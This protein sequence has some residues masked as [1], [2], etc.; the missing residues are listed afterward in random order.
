MP[1][2]ASN[3][4]HYQGFYVSGVVA[5]G[6]YAVTISPEKALADKIILTYAFP[7]DT[8]DDYVSGVF[9]NPLGTTSNAQV[10][11]NY[12]IHAKA[13]WQDDT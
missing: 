1:A 3:D 13:I 10:E 12:H 5:G 8:V 9:Y 2:I 7:S 6:D 11:M 4:V